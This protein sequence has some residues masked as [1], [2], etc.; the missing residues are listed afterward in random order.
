[1]PNGYRLQALQ[2]CGANCTT[3]YWVSASAGGTQL[4]EIDPVRGGGV[5]AVGRSDVYGDHPP[6]RNVLPSYAATDPACCPSGFAD[7]TYSWDPTT[8]ALLAEE[9]VVTPAAEFPGWD[10]VRQELNNEGWIVAWP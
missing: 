1:M 3:Q 8:N 5:L 2:V 4:L 9:P 7:T 6:V 10:A